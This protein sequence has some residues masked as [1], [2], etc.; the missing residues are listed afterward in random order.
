MKREELDKLR[1][2]YWEGKSS[3]E[4]E[5][6]LKELEDEEFFSMLKK[7]EEKMDWDFESFMDLA[8]KEMPADKKIIPLS[9]RI[10]MLT[11]IAASLLLG[12]FLIRQFNDQKDNRA[13]NKVAVSNERPK[14][15]DV[16]SPKSTPEELVASKGPSVQ[17]ESKEPLKSVQLASTRKSKEHSP[18]TMQTN[19]YP[20]EDLYVEVN[21]VRIYDEEKALEVTETAL[22]FAASNLKKGMEGVENIKYLKI[23]I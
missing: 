9:R 7:P 14:P 20:D 15:L 16:E 22:H 23:E 11:S 2:K 1:A 17:A 8:E 18:E 21:G 19:P 10:I 12:F 3:L 4:Q 13:I 5:R 6:R